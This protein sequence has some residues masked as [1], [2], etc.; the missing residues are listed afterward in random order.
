MRRLAVAVA[1]IALASLAGCSAIGGGAA[2]DGPADGPLVEAADPSANATDV[3]QTVRIEVG[4][5]SAGEEWE[6]VAVT[7]P[8][9]RFSV[10]G[11]QH[12]AVEY[13]VD[14]D[15]D[16]EIDREFDETDVS[17]VNNNAY[18]YD[19]TLET[20]YTLTEGDVIVVRYPTVDNPSEPGDYDVE[21]T[22]NRAQNETGTLTI[23][24]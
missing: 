19:L 6:S 20:G 3:T 13:G 12:D 16:G 5:A 2:D 1:V 21:V 4:E 10:G 14:T 23:E 7:Y 9:D 18:S 24:E 17:G 15:G 8:R 11:A 22:V